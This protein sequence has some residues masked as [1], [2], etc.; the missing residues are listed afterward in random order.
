V[1]HLRN[2]WAIFY[3]SCAKKSHLLRRY[4]VQL[5]S[6]EMR[7]VFSF[8]TEKCWPRLNLTGS[9]NLATLRPIRTR[10]GRKTSEP[11]MRSSWEFIN[12]QSLQR[13]SKRWTLTCRQNSFHFYVMAFY[14][15]SEMLILT[16][17]VQESCD[18]NKCW[19]CVRVFWQVDLQVFLFQSAFLP[20]QK[21]FS[22][23]NVPISR[24][25]SSWAV[26]IFVSDILNYDSFNPD[27]IKS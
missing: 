3:V 11:G 18:S 9:L 1:S 22:M 20:I 17:Y 6:T 26:T 21:R 7:L 14:P 23:I 10:A 4:H 2:I 12:K 25:Q 19:G 15:T 8:W 27:N 5:N 16:T 13:V 24:T